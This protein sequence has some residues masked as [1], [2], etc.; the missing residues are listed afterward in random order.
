M[1]ACIG[2]D[3]DNT[4]AGYDH[5]FRAAAIGRGWL[6]AG[7]DGDKRAVRD[8]LRL[9]P[10]GE[11][12]WMALQG[13]VYGPR[14]AE[15]RMLDGVDRFLRHCRDMGQRVVVVSHK[16][17]RGHFDSTGTNLRQ[18]SLAWM[19]AQGFFSDAGFALNRA[20]IHFESTREA[21][22]RRIAD[23]ACDVFIDDLEEVLCDPGFP[24]A[25]RRLHLAGDGAEALPGLTQCRG[26]AEV[27]HAVFG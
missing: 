10:D 3:F 8:A 22:V 15:A 18:A 13:E 6:A 25:C 20:D 26:W 2:I 1:A 4:I 21:K 27:F 14:M 16:T 19:D 9:M 5:V 7:F 12:Q 17:E 11:R 23:L 24:S